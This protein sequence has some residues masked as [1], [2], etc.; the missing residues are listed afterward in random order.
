[1]AKSLRGDKLINVKNKSTKSQHS[2]V[3]CELRRLSLAAEGSSWIIRYR[4][5]PELLK[6][7]FFLP[8]IADVGFFSVLEPE[9]DWIGWM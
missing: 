3:L 5:N 8:Q 1:M 9:R 7:E 4:K 2:A 6:P